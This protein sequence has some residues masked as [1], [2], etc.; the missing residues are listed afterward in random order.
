MYFKHVLEKTY[1]MHLSLITWFGVMGLLVSCVSNL[2]AKFVKND[3]V[4]GF[5]G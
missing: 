4:I 5:V 2:L 1:K 3:I